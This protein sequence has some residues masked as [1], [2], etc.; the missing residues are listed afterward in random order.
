MFITYTLPGHVFHELFAVE[1]PGV[2]IFYSLFTSV[3]HPPFTF[4]DIKDIFSFSIH[5]HT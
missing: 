4:L 2:V 1:P 5:F 3:K